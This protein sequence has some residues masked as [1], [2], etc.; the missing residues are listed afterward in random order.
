[1]N[2][3]KVPLIIALLRGLYLVIT[4]YRYVGAIV[5]LL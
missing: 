4:M 3:P 1:M 5:P 2:G